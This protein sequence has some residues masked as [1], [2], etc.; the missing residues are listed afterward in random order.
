M[1]RE[2]QLQRLVDIIKNYR[3]DELDFLIDV[4]HVEKWLNQFEVETQSVILSETIHVLTSWYFD[5]EKVDKVLNRIVRF[6][7]EVYQIDSITNLI[8]QVS[9]LTLQDAGLSQKM[10]VK[11]LTDM[12]YDQYSISVQTKIHSSIERYVYIDDGLYTGSRAIQDIRECL[13]VLPHGARLDVFYVVASERGLWRVKKEFA[14]LAEKKGINLKIHRWRWIQNDKRKIRN[15]AS[16]GEDVILNQMCL[17]PSAELKEIAQVTN[18]QKS[19]V[20]LTEKQQEYLFRD[21]QWNNDAGIFTS[22]ENRN[23]VEKEFLLKGIMILGGVSRSKGIYPLGF[24]SGVSFGFGSFCVFDMN[25]SNTCPLVLWWGR[26]TQS[27]GGLDC[28]Y[29]LFPRRINPESERMQKEEYEVY[30]WE[31]STAVDQYNMCPDCG[32]HFGIETDG[33]NGFCINCAWEH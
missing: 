19:L 1:S 8:E 17:W 26:N 21:Y 9:F 28:W 31:R 3:K 33:G 29:P 30:D 4:S 10:L 24:D 32:C 15:E 27:G 25:I 7:R 6:L 2:T 20:N 13:C 23:I 22:V 5:E 14:D 16:S 11:R 12:I 18:Y